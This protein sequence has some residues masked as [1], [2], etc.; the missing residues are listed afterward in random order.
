MS[1]RNATKQDFEHVITS[2]KKGLVNP[3]TYITHRVA[4]DNVKK[5]FESWLNPETGVIK[6]VIE[7]S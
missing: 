4:F 6:A 3:A 1:S 2:M 5:E 7:M